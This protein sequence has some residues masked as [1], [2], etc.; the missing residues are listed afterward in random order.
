LARPTGHRTLFN[1]GAGFRERARA[2]VSITKR[3]DESLFGR[4]GVFHGFLRREQLEECLEEERTSANGKDLGQILLKKGYITEEQLGVIQEIRRKKVRKMLRDMKEIERN[5][6][7]FGMIALR[8]GWISLAGL[9]AAILEQERLRKL[10]LQFRLGEVLVS[11]G[12]LDDGRVLEI[13]AEQKKRVLHC[14]TCDFHYNVFDYTGG[15][16]YR[17]KK[18]G[19]VLREP[20]FLDSVAVDGVIEDAPGRETT[21][22]CLAG[23]DASEQG[24]ER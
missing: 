22:T 3:F 11:L 15:E 4:I 24:S 16:T 10:N 20:L 23:S 19:D 9:E 5:E 13:L 6:K 1:G 2:Q 14:P 7:F 12:L 17:C 8:R 18:C 21:E